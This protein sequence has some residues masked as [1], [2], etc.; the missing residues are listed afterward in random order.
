MVSFDRKIRP[1]RGVRDIDDYLARRPDPPQRV[2]AA[3]PAIEPYVFILMPFETVWSTNV[4][5]AIGQ[6]CGQVTNQFAGLRWERADGITEPGRIT[7]Q[8]ISA[9]ERADVLVAD[10][11]DSNPNVLFELGYADA[12]NKPIIVLNQQI[13]ET[14]FDI[15][16][17]RQIAYSADN[18]RQLSKSLSGFLAGTLRTLGFPP[19]TVATQD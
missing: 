2:W 17:W 19:P 7:D 5:D 14:P 12:L 3:P 9:I 10:I 4:K 8:I 15:K 18:V 16:D 1:Y 11:T 13:A 6:A